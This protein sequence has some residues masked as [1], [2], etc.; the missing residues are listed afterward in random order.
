MGLRMESTV[1]CFPE[2]CLLQFSVAHSCAC[3]VAKAIYEQFCFP[4]WTLAAGFNNTNNNNI[5][6]VSIEEVREAV[7]EM[8][9]GKA[10]MLDGW[11]AS[12]DV[13]WK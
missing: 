7:E 13:V 12:I 10:P 1:G 4:T 3:G 9:V 2:L 6:A 11:S 5:R 8:K